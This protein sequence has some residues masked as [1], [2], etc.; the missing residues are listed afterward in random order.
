MTRR[1]SNTE[2]SGAKT[3]VKKSSK[4]KASWY[5]I[6]RGRKTGITKSWAICKEATSGVQGNLY[7]GFSDLQDAIEFMIQAG[8]ARN[9]VLILGEKG[10][11]DVPAYNCVPQIQNRYSE[12]CVDN[13]VTEAKKL[14]LESECFDQSDNLESKHDDDDDDD[15]DKIEIEHGAEIDLTGQSMSP[16]EDNK[17]CA[18]A[19]CTF[20]KKNDMLHCDS[21]DRWWHYE[22]TMLPAYMLAF[23]IQTKS[24]VF[25][26]ELCVNVPK[27]LDDLLQNKD[28][29][30]ATTS[31]EHR[32]CVDFV[33]TIQVMEKGIVKIIKEERDELKKAKENCDKCK[34]A[35]LERDEWRDK[36]RKVQSEKDELKRVNDNCEK[37]IT[38]QVLN[39]ERIYQIAQLETEVKA[40]RNEIHIITESRD[41]S[42]KILKT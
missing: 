6:A 2:K 5:A 13:D 8:I 25:V 4:T 28:R 23:L 33:R 3:P 30:E 1:R 38:A 24:S 7:Q 20:I 36:H 40:S 12:N 41:R 32:C 17:S 22:C 21:C 34:K 26:C 39:N 14:Y 31:Q 27:E 35:Q 19:L 10:E 9:D 37:C 29:G 16:T 18:K 11:E 15:D 42:I